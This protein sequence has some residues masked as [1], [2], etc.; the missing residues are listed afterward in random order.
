M[1]EQN[2]NKCKE[3]LDRIELPEDSKDAVLER[4]RSASAGESAPEP[5]FKKRFPVRRVILIAAAV[6]LLAALAVGLFVW[7]RPEAPSVPAP[8]EPS[9]VIINT[10]DG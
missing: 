6:T 2:E 3:E 10:S 4:I 1:N 7:L 9:V 5:V 8:D